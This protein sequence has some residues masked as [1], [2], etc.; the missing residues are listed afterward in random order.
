MMKGAILA[1]AM[2]GG[3]LRAFSIFLSALP[4]LFRRR[5]AALGRSLN[6]IYGK[7]EPTAKQTLLLSSRSDRSAS[8][9]ELASRRGPNT[10]WG[11]LFAVPFVLRWGEERAR[12][13]SLS[14]F[15]HTSCAAPRRAAAAAGQQAIAFFNVKAL[16]TSERTRDCQVAVFWALPVER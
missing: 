10:T 9:A 12:T 1:A 7:R 5:G 16:D 2:I 14:A 6:P 11:C 15:K 8:R 4:L 3:G 13:L